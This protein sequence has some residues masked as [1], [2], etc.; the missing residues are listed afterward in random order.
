MTK[1]TRILTLGAALALLAGCSAQLGSGDAGKCFGGQLD[2]P[3][4]LVVAPE[5]TSRGQIT[6]S[7]PAGTRAALCVW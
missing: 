7:A 4:P 5:P 3:N 6:F 2:A 1:P